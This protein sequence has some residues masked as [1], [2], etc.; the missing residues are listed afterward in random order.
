MERVLFEAVNLRCQTA[1]RSF[2]RVQRKGH[3]YWGQSV[4]KSKGLTMAQQLKSCRIALANE[5]QHS[6]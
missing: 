5:Q 6:A 3:M 1:E 4:R 2:K